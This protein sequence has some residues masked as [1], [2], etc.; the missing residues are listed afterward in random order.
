MEGVREGMMINI[1]RND[2]IKSPIINHPIRRDDS[3]K[4]PIINLPISQG[5]Q[6][7]DS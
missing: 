1:I 2:S 4:S 6:K 7:K 3:I 5:Y